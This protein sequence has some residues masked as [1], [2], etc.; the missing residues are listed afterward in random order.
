M[1][2]LIQ[3]F[4]FPCSFPRPFNNSSASQTPGPLPLFFLFE[5]FKSPTRWGQD[6]L[7]AAL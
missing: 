1:I 6:G 5:E 3:K 2:D 7:G 4:Y